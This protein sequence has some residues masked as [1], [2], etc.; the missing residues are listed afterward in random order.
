MPA[1]EIFTH[2]EYWIGP[3]KTKRACNHILSH[4]LVVPSKINTK[5]S[6]IRT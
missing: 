5:K 1:S 4:Q 3:S 2:G 6:A